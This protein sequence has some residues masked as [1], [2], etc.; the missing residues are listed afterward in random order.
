MRRLGTITSSIKWPPNGPWSSW[1]KSCISPKYGTGNKHGGTT[2]SSS[3]AHNLRVWS[4]FTVG[5]MAEIIRAGDAY[6][7]AGREFVRPDGK[8]RYHEHSRFDHVG[9]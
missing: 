6:G 1:A 3:V 9:V 7:F 4:V 8:I 2:S 5:Q